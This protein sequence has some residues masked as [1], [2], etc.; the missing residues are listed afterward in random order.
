MQQWYATKWVCFEPFIYLENMY[1]QVLQKY[2]M[3]TV[4]PLCKMFKQVV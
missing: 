4:K 3:D 1:K 2:K